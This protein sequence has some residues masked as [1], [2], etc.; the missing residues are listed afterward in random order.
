MFGRPILGFHTESKMEF[1]MDM[2]RGKVV[3]KTETLKE[4]V[5]QNTGDMTFKEVYEK[6]GWNLNITVTDF[7]LQ[8]DSRLLNY[9]TSPNVI[10]W[11]AVLASCAIPGMYQKVELKQKLADG[12][13]IQYDPSSHRMQF[14]DGS[15]GADLPMQ[16]LSELFNVNTFIVSQVNPHVC[17]F[18]AVDTGQILDTKFRKRF[19]RTVK[20]LTGN[21][22]KYFIRQLDCL[23]LMPRYIRGIVNLIIQ[24]Y[25]GHVTIVPSPSL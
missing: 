20:S 18:V 1:V 11:S 25:K 10:V 15:V 22:V 24:T 16:R 8:Q 5:R 2:L 12:S 3:L 21:T 7:S 19:L 23:G 14:V 13:I 17:P 6:H 9:L 4:Y